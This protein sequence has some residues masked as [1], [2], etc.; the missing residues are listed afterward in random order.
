MALTTVPED[1]N[2]YYANDH[3]IYELSTEYLTNLEMDDFDGGNPSAEVI[4]KVSQ[5]VTVKYALEN[6]LHTKA[7]DP[8]DILSAP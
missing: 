7:R 6:T 1:R 2:N 8:L 3:K 4:K 5:A